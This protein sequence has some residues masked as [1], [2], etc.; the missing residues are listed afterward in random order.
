MCDGTNPASARLAHLSKRLRQ[1]CVSLTPT[2]E[3]T[4]SDRRNHLRGVTFDLEPGDYVRYDVVETD[5]AAEL[6]GCSAANVRDLIRRDR[7]PAR[8]TGNRWLV[9]SSAVVELA[10]RKAARR[11]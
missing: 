2:Q 5:E 4:G 3:K 8:R 10:Q 6:L 11:A 7:L 1:A 9:S